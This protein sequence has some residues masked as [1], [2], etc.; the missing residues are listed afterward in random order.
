MILDLP[1][2]VENTIR[3]RV[4]ALAPLA[5]RLTQFPTLYALNTL[6]AGLVLIATIIAFSIWLVFDRQ[7]RIATTLQEQNVGIRMLALLGSGLVCCIPFLLLVFIT[8]TLVEKAKE[9]P[10]WIKVEK[11]E[12]GGLGFGALG[13]ALFLTVLAAV[14]PPAIDAFENTPAN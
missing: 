4:D 5:D 14:A 1:N 2:P 12:V 9:L 13:C 3:E 7:S 6:V 10:S 11:G 8:H